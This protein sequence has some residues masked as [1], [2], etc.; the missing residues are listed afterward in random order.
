MSNF[1]VVSSDVEGW[2]VRRTG[3]AQGDFSPVTDWL[4]SQ[5][6]GEPVPFPAA[7]P[8]FAPERHPL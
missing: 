8:Y 5:S 4:V 3:E 1:E 2:D 7:S 6:S